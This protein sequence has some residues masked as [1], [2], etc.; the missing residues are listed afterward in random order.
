MKTNE[1]GLDRTLRIVAGIA[2]IGLTLAGT[3]GAWGWIGVV[4]LLTGLVGTCPLYRI[5]GINTCPTK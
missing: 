5:V 1:G 4:P 3:I 2:L